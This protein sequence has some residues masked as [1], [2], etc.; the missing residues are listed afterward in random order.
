MKNFIP[1]MLFSLL[2]LACEKETQKSPNIEI[3]TEKS[4]YAINSKIAVTIRNNLDK[5]A[6]Y[7]KC[8]NVDICPSEILAHE[9]GTWTEIDNPIACTQTGPMGYWGVL[10]VA[11][12]K[13]DTILLPNETGKFKLRYKL[14]VENDTFNFDSNEFLLYALL[15]K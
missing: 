3:T 7:F 6:Y 12:T 1:I 5:Q 4:E 8:D 13:H 2:A 9:N 10:T 11:E 14:I 15:D